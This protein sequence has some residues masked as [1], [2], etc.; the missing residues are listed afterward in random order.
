[1]MKKLRLGCIGC[2]GIMETHLEV[3]LKHVPDT[4]VVALC[5][6]NEENMN[7][8]GDKY[9]I[10]SRYTNY[11]ELL[12]RRDIDAV[13]I[14]VRPEEA[15][16]EIVKAA[17]EAMKHIFLEKP[18]AVS[19]ENAEEMA[20][21]IRRNRVK[22]QI[23]FHRRF[24]SEFKKAKEIIGSPEFGEV[25]GLTVCHPVNGFPMVAFLAQGPHSLD[26]LIFLGGPVEKISGYCYKIRAKSDQEYAAAISVLPKKDWTYARNE[27]KIIDLNVA[28]SLQFKNGAVGSY[29]FSSFGGGNPPMQFQL[30]GKN[31]GVIVIELGR[32]GS[33][34]SSTSANVKTWEAGQGMEGY[35]GEFQHFA[36]YVLRD[37]TPIISLDEGLQGVRLYE[38]ILKLI[39]KG[40]DIEVCLN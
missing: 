31:H 8:L 38:A 18:M 36:D 39:A 17:A 20:A 19:M 35:I 10:K 15:K 24:L 37:A 30:F 32:G 4:E 5:D 27:E 16:P 28:V 26:S 12:E 34:Y 33:F 21:T 9:N 6:I 1:M 14:A 40:G 25:T 2:G 23:G 13:D 22:F 7:R 29:V 3:I 11:K